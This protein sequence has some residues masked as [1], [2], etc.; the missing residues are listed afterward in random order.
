[1]RHPWGILLGWIVAIA[2]GALGAHHFE[3]VALGGGGGVHGSPSWRAKETLRT[4]FSN[5]FI[6]PLVV[7]VSARRARADDELYFSWIRQAAGALTSLPEV[8]RVAS[9]ADARDPDVRS[10]DGHVTLLLVGLASTST[11]ARQQG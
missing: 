8:R 10:A 2:L 1:M 5:P 11:T 9:Y 3:E 4:D 7:A 6:D